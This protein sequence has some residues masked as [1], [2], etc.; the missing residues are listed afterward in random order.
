MSLKE[1]C[2]KTYDFLIVGG[3]T[4]GLVLAARLSENPNVTVGVI[5]AGQNRLDDP[6][7]QAPGLFP[8]LYDKSEY[9]WKF[10]TKA[11]AKTILFLDEHS[12]PMLTRS[13]EACQQSHH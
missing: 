10:R 9:D 4:A 3:G 8:E 11:Q 12:T 1:F 5:E 2:S 7:I 6:L 13:I